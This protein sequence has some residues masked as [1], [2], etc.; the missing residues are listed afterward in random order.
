MDSPLTPSPRCVR[1][2]DVGKHLEFGDGSAS[3][4]SCGRAQ[5]TEN[6]VRGC[7]QVCS[8][9]QGSWELSS[10]SRLGVSRLTINQ[11]LAE[12]K[13][14]GFLSSVTGS[15]MLKNTVDVNS[16]LRVPVFITS[17]LQQRGTVLVVTASLSWNGRHPALTLKPPIAYISVLFKPC[18]AW[19]HLS[20]HCCT[21]W[22]PC[23]CRR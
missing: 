23:N 5:A 7:L 18:I 4:C 8:Y 14:S 17:S 11:Q 19:W 6:Q 2:L 15:R 9:V 20:F 12:Y 1:A 21:D 13:L 22:Q 3:I 16:F 10:R